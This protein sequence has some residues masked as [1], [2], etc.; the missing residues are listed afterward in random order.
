MLPTTSTTAHDTARAVDLHLLDREPEAVTAAE[1]QAITRDY[2]ADAADPPGARASGCRC[3]PPLLV[4][5]R[6]CGKCGRDRRP[7]TRSGGL[8]AHQRRAQPVLRRAAGAAG[9]VNGPYEHLGREPRSARDHT[10]LWERLR[11]IPNAPDDVRAA[12]TRFCETKLITTA[13]LEA[14][15]ARVTRREV[16]WCLAFAGSNGRGQITAIKYR[17][18]NGTSHDSFAEFGSVWVRPIVIGEVTSLDWVIAEGET[19]GARLWGLVG[20]RC[21]IL[22]MPLGARTFR[23]E[24]AR[25]IPRGATVALCHDADPDGDA[26]AEDAAQ[27]IGGATV[28]VRPPIEGGDWC[29][30]PGT[31][32]EFV[33]LARPRGR[34][35]FASFADFASRAFPV[36]APLLG[37]PGKVFLAGGSLLMTYGADGSGKSTFTV[38]GLTH[39]AA[40]CSWLGIDVPRAVRCCIVENE[41]PPALFQAK[42]K[43][44]ARAVGRRRPA[45]QPVRVRRAMGRVHVR[46]PR[47][48]RDADRVLRR[49]SD[50]RHRREPHPRARRRCVGQARRDPAVRRL[51]RRMRTEARPRVLAA[52]PREQERADLG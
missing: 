14:M 50:R 23:P 52:A 31:A 3:D 5:P 12:I 21:A 43:A 40:G 22:V 42:L 1:A 20:D 33:K 11:T 32:E 28:R 10:E 47:S 35:E 44:K 19:D 30:W 45:R 24:W 4:S 18:L 38:D 27:T 17:P 13:A 51:A 41:G 49:A 25:V 36:A 37:K 39:L 2:L 9:G 16:G 8:R 46:R 6:H 29:D 26:G 34:F 48:A 7:E 15:G